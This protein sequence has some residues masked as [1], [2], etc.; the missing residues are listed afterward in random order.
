MLSRSTILT[1]DVEYRVWTVILDFSALS[2]NDFRK[3]NEH[4]SYT[5][6]L[7]PNLSI[8]VLV[9]FYCYRLFHEN[10]KPDDG[11]VCII[12]AGHSRSLLGI[13]VFGNV[14]TGVFIFYR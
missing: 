12:G 2:D 4:V 5:F 3:C 13:V 14:S 9:L 6:L 10:S 7:A 1:V 11:L 8:Y